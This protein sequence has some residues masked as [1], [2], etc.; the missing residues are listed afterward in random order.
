MTISALLLPPR[1][2]SNQVTTSERQLLNAREATDQRGVSNEM[3][4]IA[5]APTPGAWDGCHSTE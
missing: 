4:M 1:R 2:R 5:P 3:R